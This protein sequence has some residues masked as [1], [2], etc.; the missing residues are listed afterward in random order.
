MNR[1]SLASQ[2]IQALHARSRDRYVSPVHVAQVYAGLGALDET[3]S[4]LERG[5][6]CRAT[7]LIWLAVRPAWKPLRGD[8]RYDELLQRLRLPSDVVET[9]STAHGS[10]T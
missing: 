5:F 3:F 4:W 10:V 7:E 9:Q 2:T 1:R 6:E 8:Q